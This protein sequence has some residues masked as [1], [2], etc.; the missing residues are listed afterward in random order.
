MTSLTKAQNTA[1]DTIIIWAHCSKGGIVGIVSHHSGELVPADEQSPEQ[2]PSFP[3]GSGLG[4]SC[5][6]GP[7]LPDDLSLDSC[8]QSPGG[9]S[10]V[11]TFIIAIGDERVGHVLSQGLSAGRLTLNVSFAPTPTAVAVML[12]TVSVGSTVIFLEFDQSSF[13]LLGAA[14]VATTKGDGVPRVIVS[15]MVVASSVAAAPSTVPRTCCSSG[16]DLVP[17]SRLDSAAFALP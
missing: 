15:T 7:F 5:R 11:A 9:D 3:V 10:G 17:G 13:R 1:N 2:L 6:E 4:F 14:V 12:V 8:P 16:R